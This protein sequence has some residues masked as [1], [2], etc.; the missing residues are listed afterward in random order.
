MEKLTFETTNNKDEYK[1]LVAGLSIAK[2]LGA[3]EVE[4]KA[5]SQIVVDQVLRVY[6]AKGEKLKQY[7]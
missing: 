2:A 1:A 4:V 5:D 3:T 6:S 7:L